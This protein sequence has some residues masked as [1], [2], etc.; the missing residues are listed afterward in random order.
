[1]L[2]GTRAHRKHDQEVA[3]HTCASGACVSVTCHSC[4][5]AGKAPALARVVSAEPTHTVLP[6]SRLY[7][8]LAVICLPR[9]VYYS[10][11]TLINRCVINAHPPRVLR[12]RAW[13]GHSRENAPA[14]DVEAA[15]RAAQVFVSQLL[16]DDFE[17]P[18]RARNGV[19]LDLHASVVVVY[20]R[21]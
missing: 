2:S 21:W 7:G 18:M 12:Q 1:M 9:A 10:R 17:A 16:I 19:V 15:V 11:R 6:S 20:K 13:G 14:V 3:C 4:C 5:R 8:C